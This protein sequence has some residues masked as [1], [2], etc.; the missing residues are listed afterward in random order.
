M[1]TVPAAVHEGALTAMELLRKPSPWL[2]A[3]LLYWGF[4]IATLW[5]SFHAFGQAPT[6]PILV[7]GYFVGQLGN[8]LPLPGGIGGVEGGMIGAF[9]GFGSSGSLA[10]IAVLTYRLISYWLPMLPGGVAYFTLRR[11]VGTWR[12]GSPRAS[13]P[14]AASASAGT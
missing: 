10:V 4:D 13:G 7:V 2:G 8:T 1:A 12:A 11:T 3:A 6:V 14:E 9:I 5:A